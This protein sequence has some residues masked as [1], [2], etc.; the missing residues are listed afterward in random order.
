M[1]KESCYSNQVMNS[2]LQDL[3]HG[4]RTLTKNPGF[5][6][7]AVLTL[8]LGVGAN[9]AIFSV[10]R[11]TLLVPIPIPEPERVVMLWT[12]N[13]EHDYHLARLP[14]S[15]PDF[16]DWKSSGIFEHMGAVREG[17]FNLRTGNRTDRVMGVFATD[18]W[19]AAFGIKPRM[20]RLFR[21][22]D[23][24]PGHDQVVILSHDCWSSTFAGDPGVI[25]KSVILDGEARTVVGVLPKDF[26]KI[27]H[28]QVYAPLVFQGAAATDRGSRFMGVAGKLPRGVGLAAAQQRMNELSRRLSRQYEQDAGNTVTL[29]PIEE[30]FVEDV[31]A[32]VLVVAGAVGFVLLI[33]CA[34]IANLLLARGTGRT[35]EMA[36]RAALGAGR[37]TLARQLIAESIVLAMIGGLVAILVAAWGVEFIR[38]FKI[39]DIPNAE[40]VKLDA[41]VLAFNFCVALMTG[42]LFG[43]APAWQAWKT[44]VN[45]TLKAAGRGLSSGVHQRLRGLFVVSEIAL[46]LVLLVGAGLMLKSFA[47]LRSADP[48][49][50]PQGVLTMKIALSDRQYSTPEKQ[51]AYFDQALRRIRALPGVLSAGAIDGLPD[52]DDVHGSGLRRADRPEPK[53]SD[54]PIVLVSSVTPDY[55]RAMQARLLRGRYFT[56]ADRKGAPPVAIIDIWT[57]KRYWPDTDPLG[58][59]LRLGKTDGPR[60]IVGIVG[61]TS[62]GLLIKMVKGQVGQ[63]YRPF[64]Q[65][66]KAELSL[67]IRTAGDPTALGATVQKA[68]REIDADEPAFQVQDMEAARASIAAPQKLATALLGAFACLA[69][70]LA[71][72]GIYGVVA[73]SAGRRMRE[74]GIRVALGAG[75]RDVLR[76]LVGQGMLLALIGI[77]I[78]FAGAWALTR[79]MASLLS[80]VEP[81]DPA[82]FAGVCVLLAAAA[83]I[84]SYV[85]ALR[86]TRVDPVEALRQE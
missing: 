52:G 14:A 53:L 35:R 17:G 79:K 32:L 37:W 76:L 68:L 75:R 64:G 21:E 50:N 62:Q 56:D 16:Q 28:E 77:A 24:Q 39:E 59:S 34:N 44:D 38:W 71:V 49:F 36:V 40:L 81:T 72:I 85:P 9:T 67:A 33:A 58:K 12:E 2:L 69:L 7:V 63:V 30:A 31:A 84:A 61:G 48:G 51:V 8:G 23:T 46:T 20:G 25:G 18:G 47:S 3:R 86:A 57:A 43:L 19:F 83:M 11:A 4:L 70:L 5:A 27:G 6:A 82:T 26:P 80:G 73:Y 74:I 78:G 15:I 42:V 41:A 60:E 22:A 29:Q 13:R 10:V 1:W 45:D 54:V 66:P 55:F 65:E